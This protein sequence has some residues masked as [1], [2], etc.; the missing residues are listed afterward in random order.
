MPDDIYTAPEGGGIYT[1]RLSDRG[2]YYGG[3]TQDFRARWRQHLRELRAGTHGNIRMQWTFDKYQVF[4]PEVLMKLAVD[5]QEGAEQAWL[6][7][8]FRQPGCVNARSSASLGAW[9]M[10]HEEDTRALISKQQ[11]GRVWV[12]NGEVNRRVFPEEAAPFLE[13]GWLSGRKPRPEGVPHGNKGRKHTDEARAKMSASKKGLERSAEA[14]V[15]TAEA[16]LGQRRSDESRSKMSESAG[17]WWSENPEAR[18]QLSERQRGQVWVTDGE[19]STRVHPDE[20]HDY[21]DRGWRRGRSG[22]STKGLVWI[23]DGESGK[24]VPPDE[25]QGWVDKGWRIGQAKCS[26]TGRVWINDGK[27]GKR[28]QPEELQSWLDRGWRKG[29]SKGLAYPPFDTSSIPSD[30]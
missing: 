26:T 16:N 6:D 8:N 17:Q 21:L 12:N 30:R 5:D 28:V 23:T 3:R 22:V 20:L 15:K 7:A 18:E 14:I 25:V 19:R 9:K 10:T 24:R 1:L 27:R 4:R 29:S 2:H 11:K 13:S